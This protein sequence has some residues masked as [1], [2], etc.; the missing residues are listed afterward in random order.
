MI[1][2]TGRG[3]PMTLVTGRGSPMTLARGREGR[4]RE[5]KRPAYVQEDK[6]KTATE[7]EI[8]RESMSKEAEKVN[9][10]CCSEDAST[11]LQH[12]LYLSKAV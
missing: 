5:G 1:L 7:E 11:I 6:A 3:S 8:V 2:V 4:G 9:G 12:L 10:V